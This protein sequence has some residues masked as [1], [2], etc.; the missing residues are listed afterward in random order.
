MENK[1]E[2]RLGEIVLRT[3]KFDEM[4]HFYQSIIDLE[5]YWQS[6]RSC[7]FKISE[8]FIGHPQL[9]AVFKENVPSNGPSEPEYSGINTERTT[10][11]HFAFAMNKENF[12]KQRV[13]LQ[14]KPVKLRYDTHPPH[15]WESLYIYDPQG[16]TVEF[17]T[18]NEKLKQ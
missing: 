13:Y 4:I 7:F 1:I 5:I 16:N 18:Y 17:V 9:V 11:H 15:N 2:K 14:N 10:L 8:D 12:D 3:S 6:K